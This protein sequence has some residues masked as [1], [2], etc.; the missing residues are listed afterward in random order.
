M[1]RVRIVICWVEIAAGEWFLNSQLP[2]K[3]HGMNGILGWPGCGKT[4]EACQ[5]NSDNTSQETRLSDHMI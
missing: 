2:P 4:G 1:P 5:T 3:P